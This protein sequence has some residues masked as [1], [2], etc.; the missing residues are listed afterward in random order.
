MKRFSSST[1]HY[2]CVASFGLGLA[3]ISTA[4]MLCAF[5]SLQWT[6]F[7]I[8]ILWNM[9]RAIF[10]SFAID[11]NCRHD[12]AN[13]IITVISVLTAIWYSKWRHFHKVHKFPQFSFHFHATHDQYFSSI[14]T[15]NVCVCCRHFCIARYGFAVANGSFFKRWYDGVSMY[16]L[17]KSSNWV[18][19]ISKPN[20]FP[21]KPG[22]CQSCI[23]PLSERYIQYNINASVALEFQMLF[24]SHWRVV[25]SIS[26]AVPLLRFRN[27]LY[28]VV[29]IHRLRKREWY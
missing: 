22:T 16:R 5:L 18:L 6:S 4:L 20:S 29:K 17:T 13:S 26:F 7:S 25:L 27:N 14:S 8:N 23:I 9:V 28:E 11:V 10:H 24:S 15:R 1:S 21:E 12:P 19:Y 2:S 3:H